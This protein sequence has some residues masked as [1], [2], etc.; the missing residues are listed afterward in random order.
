MESTTLKREKYSYSRLEV[1]ESCPFKYKLIYVDKIDAFT[2]SVA[3]EIGTL[4]HA[5]EEAI[6]RSIQANKPIEYDALKQHFVDTLVKIQN[7]YPVD[8]NTP[9]KA[10]T[11]YNEKIRYYLNEGIYRL[12]HLM[13]EHPSYKI[14]GI[15]QKF[16]FEYK[17]TYLFKGFIDRVFYDTATDQYIIQDIKTWA[18]P[19]KDTEL[20]TPLQFVVYTLAARTLWNANSDQIRCEYDLPFC[21]ITQSAG[22]KGYLA[23]G[24]TKLDKLFVAITE[25]EF[26][27]S[28]SPLCNYCAFCPTNPDAKEKTKWLCPY[29]SHWTRTN[30]NDFTKENE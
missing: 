13:Q 17:Q 25:K 28:A 20:T 3:T 23:R 19:K 4:V 27:P 22:T 11:T 18:V 29:F 15:E 26:E 10:G 16:E 14:I 9:D 6:A 12:E 30:R 1:Y 21:N 24:T 5:T 8:Y 2:Q 7:K